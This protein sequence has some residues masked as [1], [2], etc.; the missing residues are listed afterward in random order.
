VN[1][2]TEDEETIR[3]R[4]QLAS[5]EIRLLEEYDYAVVNDVVDKACDK[6]MSIIIA[7]HLR[8]ERILS[9][10]KKWMNEVNLSC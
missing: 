5:D 4:M 7:E 10:I 3:R 2:G 6:I 8:K 1:R 9:K